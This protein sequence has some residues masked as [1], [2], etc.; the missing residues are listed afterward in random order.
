VTLVFGSSLIGC[1]VD[2][3]IFFFA[4]RFRDPAAWEPARALPH[5][6]A[7]IVLG[8]ATT[9]LSYLAM[10]LAPFPGL[11]QIALF[12]SVGLGVAC[13]CVLFLMPRLAR[14][15]TVP[16]DA[17]VLSLIRGLSA[18]PRLSGRRSMLVAVLLAAVTAG[19]LWH[20]HF[21]DDV[22]ALQS[23]PPELLMQEVRMRELLGQSPDRRF[24]L[25]RGDDTEQVLQR[26]ETLRQHLAP[27]LADGRLGNL[28]AVS[29]ALPSLRTQQADHALLAQKVY[30]PGGLLPRLLRELG[31]DEGA[32][33]KQLADFAAQ[34]QPLLPEAFFAS[35][36]ARAYQPLW[37]GR[38]GDAQ[39]SAVTLFDVRDDAA[40]AQAAAGLPG[41]QLIDKL[42]DISEV[43]QRYRRIALWLTAG[44]YLLIGLLMWERY[45]LAGAAGTLLPAVGGG[46]LGL[47]LL[48]WA[49]VPVNL[50]HVLALLLVL[51]MAS[52]YTIFL[53]ES[54]GPQ[55][56]VLLAVVLAM[57]TAT[58]SFGL[59]AF[60]STPFIRS[61]GEVQALG[62]GLAV[63]MAL[64]W[65]PAPP[66]VPHT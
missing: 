13:G 25:V 37:L 64:A 6:A 21:Q 38:V 18:L 61:I 22:R 50:F 46:L 11:R 62:L 28:L 5:V 26:E 19:G 53:R 9:A 63:A 20:L 15:W 66:A 47:A 54:R 42:A 57:L 7:G 32:I 44:A 60:S 1:S 14:S 59:L 40:L 29:S 4:D 55:G 34:Q 36:A 30:A 39:A 52:D 33:A 8:Y 24:F 43:L 51:G 31:Y 2:Y 23:S 41:V 65:R 10:L 58:L 35:P 16:T 3:A 17:P 12:S 27:L 48:A 56:P 45:G 49:G